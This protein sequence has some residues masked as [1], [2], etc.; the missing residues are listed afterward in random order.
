[1]R[2]VIKIVS[3]NTITLVQG[4]IVEQPDRCWWEVESLN[5]H[6]QERSRQDKYYEEHAPHGNH[7]KNLKN[8]SHKARS[9]RLIH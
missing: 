7:E 5:L 8:Q 1:M 2:T 3:T 9:K 4:K 6:Y